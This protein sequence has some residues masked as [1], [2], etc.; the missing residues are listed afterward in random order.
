VSSKYNIDLVRQMA[1]CDANY[2]RLLKLVPGLL[3][4][5]DDNSLQGTVTEFSISD[6]PDDPVDVQVEITVLESFRYTT[7]LKIEQKPRSGHWL[8]NPAMEVRVYH[9]ASTAE[10]IACRDHRNFEPRYPQPNSLMFQRDEKLQVNRFL[11]EWLSHCLAVGRC[12]HIPELVF[13]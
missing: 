9:D 1:E 8:E 12:T 2:I 7:T 13:S 3:R 11:G 6:Q 10:V 5:P 4:C